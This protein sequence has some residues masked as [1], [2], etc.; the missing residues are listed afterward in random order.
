MCG[1]SFVM[2]PPTC[3]LLQGVAGPRTCLDDMRAHDYQTRSTVA[4]H[5]A[6]FSKLSMLS[7]ER[8]TLVGVTVAPLKQGT[9]QPED[10]ADR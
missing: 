6:T 9:T 7:V 5:H 3:T 10:F 2:K 4:R 8:S 1:S